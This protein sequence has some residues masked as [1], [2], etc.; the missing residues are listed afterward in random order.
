MAVRSSGIRPKNSLMFRTW[1]V[2][3]AVWWQKLACLCRRLGKCE[4]LVDLLGN[5]DSVSKSPKS[6]KSS[7]KSSA[8]LL[9]FLVTGLLG[10]A[11]SGSML[12]P[13]FK[14]STSELPSLGFSVRSP[15]SPSFVPGHG[16][17]VVH[18]M[19]SNEQTCLWPLTANLT[20][21][22]ILT[23]QEWFNA[24]PKSWGEVLLTGFS[25]LSGT[26]KGRAEVSCNGWIMRMNFHK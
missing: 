20:K 21:S 18:R 19:Q 25:L 7:V 4:T 8:C 5:S 12:S 6:S 16:M 22:S 15:L 3:E 1:T 2:A 26:M 14:A 23:V 17:S 10:P 9:R 24:E 11:S 13:S